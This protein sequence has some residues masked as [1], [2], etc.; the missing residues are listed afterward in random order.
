MT[1]TY[2]YGH[3]V[4]HYMQLQGTL[5]PKLIIKDFKMYMYITHEKLVYLRVES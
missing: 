5:N 2:Q 1:Y 4:Y 3:Y